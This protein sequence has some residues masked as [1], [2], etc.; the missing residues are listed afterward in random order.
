MCGLRQAR[1]IPGSAGRGPSGCRAPDSGW[2]RGGEATL[3]AFG[4]TRG[5]KNPLSFAYVDL[6]RVDYGS[7]FALTVPLPLGTLPHR[8]T[9]GFDAQRQ[10]DSR[11]NYGNNAG[12]AD[13]SVRTLDQVER[14]M[15]LGP[16]VQSAIDLTP[17]TT[18]T[19]GAR[20]DRVSFS[21]TDRLVDS[22]KAKSN[23]I[24]LDDS[25]RR[26][27]QQISWSVGVSENPWAALTLYASVGTS[28]E[29]PTTTELANRPDTAGGF[30]DALEP[31][32][33]RSYEIG[34]RG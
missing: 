19:A 29:T 15:E 17:R 4:F 25:G 26:A 34:M 12:L 13:T 9:A 24:Y 7:R 10:R 6:D 20:Y 3:T 23:Q 1:S 28:F 22:A 5:L 18:L 27:M 14:V 8:L 33:A 11:R 31:Q 21:A 32:T 16:F 2:G 30:N